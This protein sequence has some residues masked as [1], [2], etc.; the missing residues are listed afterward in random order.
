MHIINSAFFTQ[1]SGGE[2]QMKYDQGVGIY[3]S[4]REDSIDFL[5]LNISTRGIK[6]N[7]KYLTSDFYNG[8]EIK[9]V[10]NNFGRATYWFKQISN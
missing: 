2:I 5:G 10:Y 6:L 8:Y 3:L 9:V 7:G 4:N 1:I